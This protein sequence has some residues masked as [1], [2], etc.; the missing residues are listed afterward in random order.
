MENIKMNYLNIMEKKILVK[1]KLMKLEE[2]L[3]KVELMIMLTI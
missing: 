1:K 2:Y 3:K